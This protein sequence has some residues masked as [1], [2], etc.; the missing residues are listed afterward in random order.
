MSAAVSID[1]YSFFF[2]VHFL[3]SIFLIKKIIRNIGIMSVFT[4]MLLERRSEIE[5]MLPDKSV[6]N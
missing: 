3:F 1:Q 5:K 2:C 4:Q 6:D